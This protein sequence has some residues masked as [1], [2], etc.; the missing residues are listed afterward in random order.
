[1]WVVNGNCFV[2]ASRYNCSLE[3]LLML[4]LQSSDF[5]LNVSHIRIFSQALVSLAAATY[6]QLQQPDF[7]GFFHV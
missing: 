7:K 3:N 2:F 4:L 6:P 1:M 5:R